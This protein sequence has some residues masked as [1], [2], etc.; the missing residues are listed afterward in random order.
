MTRV[1][2]PSSCSF[3]VISY[4]PNLNASDSGLHHTVDRRYGGIVRGVPIGIAHDQARASDERLNSGGY[5]L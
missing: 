2:A 5:T 3:V 1:C 4:R